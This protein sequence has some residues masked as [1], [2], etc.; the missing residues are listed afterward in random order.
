MAHS[1]ARRVRKLLRYRGIDHF[2]DSAVA[3]GRDD[4]G[5]GVR[6]SIPR[7]ARRIASFPGDLDIDF[8]TIPAQ[9]RNSVAEGL[10]APDLPLRIILWGTGLT[11]NASGRDRTTNQ[12][13]GWL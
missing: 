13:R 9:S 7:K 1:P 2:I 10:L 8:E 11:E 6:R 5:S 12:F 3:A 4:T